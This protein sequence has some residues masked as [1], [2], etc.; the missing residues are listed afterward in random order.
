MVVEDDPTALMQGRD[1]QLDHAIAYLKQKIAERPV[2]RPEP[3]PFPNK[4][5]GG[6]DTIKR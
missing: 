5:K 1:P 2:P 3:P 4:A 6:S